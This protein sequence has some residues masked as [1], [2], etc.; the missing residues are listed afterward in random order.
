MTFAIIRW[1]LSRAMGGCET[2]NNLIH[3]LN[4]CTIM[5]LPDFSEMCLSAQEIRVR[6]VLLKLK[7]KHLQNVHTWR[8]THI[9]NPFSL[10][11]VYPHDAP[12]GYP[13]PLLSCIW[14]ACSL[15]TLMTHWC[16]SGSCLDK[17]SSKHWNKERNPSYVV[18]VTTS[19]TILNRN[20]T[21]PHL[22]WTKKPNSILTQFM[23]H[24]KSVAMFWQSVV[25]LYF[26]YILG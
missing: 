5:T 19:I 6:V 24:F 16:L 4:P 1:Y 23:G 2:C 3:A 17:A 20:S 22:R 12:G 15:S 21:T 14:P 13:N 10:D 11:E 8:K 9:I 7:N 26:F 18:Y 25:V